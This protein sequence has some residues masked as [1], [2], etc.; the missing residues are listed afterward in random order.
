[1]TDYNKVRSLWGTTTD[2]NPLTIFVSPVSDKTV[3]VICP[4]CTWENT[5]QIDIDTQGHR[6][7]DGPI[8]SKIINGEIQEDFQMYRCPG[9]NIFFS[10]E[11]TN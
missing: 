2:S 6:E 11:K 4:Y 7:C 3:V 1:M 9:Y 5:H 10:P 8:Q